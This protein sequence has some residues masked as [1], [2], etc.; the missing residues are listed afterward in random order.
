MASSNPS[1]PRLTRKKT[2]RLGALTLPPPPHDPKER[3]G[4]V[5]RERWRVDDL[6]WTTPQNSLYAATHRAGTRAAIWVLAPD[7]S[8]DPQRSALFVETA[9]AVQRIQHDGAVRILDDD[10]D[11]DGAVFLVVE[12]FDATPLK[13][14]LDASEGAF[15]VEEVLHI[16]GGILEVLAAAHAKGVQHGA[17]RAE[18]VFITRQG[19]VKILGF[20]GA[21]LEP[22][23]FRHDTAAAGALLYKMLAGGPPKGE[24][25]CVRAP[26]VPAP[27]AEVVDRAL[28]VG[29]GQPWTDAEAMYA[30]FQSARRGAGT[31]SLVPPPISEQMNP[32]FLGAPMQIR[33]ALLSG[34]RSL[35][36]RVTRRPKRHALWAIAVL[37]FLAVG[38]AAAT[39]LRILPFAQWEAAPA[40]R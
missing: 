23:N 9:A 14:M 35:R 1:L 18:D 28:G 3:I 6:L 26:H 33:R 37:V 34:R 11:V 30:A 20:G 19:Q 21:A 13:W 2:V 15:D 4:R 8:R 32:L 36:M 7:L 27:L 16:G 31:V 25:L 22:V 40:D 17:L 38:L 24:S 29:A 10:T 5:L 12:L 39:S